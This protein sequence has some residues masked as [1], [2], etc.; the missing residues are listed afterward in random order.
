MTVRLVVVA[1]ALASSAR[2][3]F[4][5][6]EDHASLEPDTG[7]YT[8]GGIG[9]YPSPLGRA[10]GALGPSVFAWANV[11]ACGLVVVLVAVLASRAGGS[12]ALAAVVALVTPLAYWT[13][14][15]GVD[16]IAACL[17]VAAGVCAL[18]SLPRG[19]R[20]PGHVSLPPSG[21]HLSVSA[22]LS[23]WARLMRMLEHLFPRPRAARFPGA[24]S[25]AL[26]SAA[27]FHL[28]LAPALALE[29]ARRSPRAAAAVALPL[30]LVLVVTPYGGV[31][32]AL[33]SPLHALICGALTV[34]FALLPY[35]VAWRRLWALRGHLWPL[36]VGTGVAAF[37]QSDGRVTNLRYALP[38]ALVLAAAAAVPV[39]SADDVDSR[40]SS[41][42]LVRRALARLQARAAVA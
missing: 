7:L 22:G 27:A 13:I 30:L 33:A 10:L 19:G 25:L 23:R 14:F 17:V 41:R 38:L 36:V 6:L 21:C 31:V 28:A 2:A 16:C 18:P 4:F 42:S 8:Q 24:A 9:L 40:S 12:P 35:S 29:A 11:V 32:G 39:V 37:L 3:A 1:A 34:A 26:V 15:S 20:V 5:W